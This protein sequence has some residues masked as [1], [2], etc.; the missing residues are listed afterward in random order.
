M[1]DVLASIFGGSS[2][3]KS[4]GKRSADLPSPEKDEEG[5]EMP[6]TK[7]QKSNKKKQAKAEK[8]ALVSA[9]H[10]REKELYR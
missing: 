10:Y 3:S 4:N 6:K 5:W 7:K 2:S 8:R 1:S 9:F